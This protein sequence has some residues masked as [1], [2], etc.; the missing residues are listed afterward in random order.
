MRK[1]ILFVSILM[2]LIASISAIYVEVGSGTATTNY[3]PA[4]GFYSYGWSR[5]I[6]LQSELIN[7]MEITAISYDVNNAPNNFNLNN[8]SYYMRHTTDS[9]IASTDY[10]DPATDTSFELVFSGSITYDGSG[11]HQLLLDTA[12]D[13]NGTD[14]LEI[15]VINNMGSWNSPYP[16]F[17]GTNET[18]ERAVYQYAD[19]TFPTGTG[20]YSG[21]FPNARFYFTAEGEP[22][23]ATLTTPSNNSFNVQAPMELAWTNGAD[24]D[25]VK[26]YLSD[27]I[28]QVSGMNPAALLADNYIQESYTVAELTSLTNYYWRI[29]SANEAT[30]FLVP[31]A[32]WKFTTAAADGSIV[33]GN[34]TEIN[35]SL[36]MEPYWGYTISQSIYE[37]E[38][39]DVDDQVIQQVSYYYNGN[40]S[41]TED[42]KVYL[43]HTTLSSFTTTGSWVPADELLLVY[44]GPMSV[45]SEEGWVTINLSAPFVY[46][47]TDNLLVAFSCHTPGYHS[48][49]DE[50]FGTTT[51]EQNSIVYYSDSINSNFV[52]PSPGTLKSIIP[53]ILLT[54]VDI[55]TGASIVVPQTSLDYGDIYLNRTGVVELTISNWGVEDLE[56]DF[57]SAGTELTFTPADLTITSSSTA[58]VTVELDPLVEG[59]YSG[60]FIINSNDPEHPAI[61]IHTT[62]FILP[63]LPEGVAMIG[64]G[65]LT[66]QGLP[67]EPFYRHSYSQSIYYGNE[68]GI[69]NQQLETIS[70]HYNGN[71]AWGPDEFKIYMGLTT[72]TQFSGNTGWI[73]ADDMMEVFDGTI[74]VPSTAGLVEIVLDTP[75]NYNSSQNLVVGVFYSNASYHSSSDE[76]YCTP[77]DVT[78]SILYYGDGTPPTH[79]APPTANYMRNCYPN[80]RL[81]FGEVPEG[82]AIRINPVAIDFGN[83]YLNR[84][85]TARFNIRNIGTETLTGNLPVAETEL[86]FSLGDFVIEPFEFEQVVVTLTPIAEGAYNGSFIID[87]NDPVHLVTTVTTT[88]NIL[89]ALPEGLVIIGDGTLVDQGLPIEPWWRHSYSQSIYYADEIGL[90]DQRVE[91]IS[92]H[93]NGDSAWGPDAIKIYMG[94]TDETS[95]SSTS[96]W[97]SIDDMMEVYDGGITVSAV[98]E[99]IEIILDI[100]FNYSDSQNLVVA[101]FKTNPDYHSSNS[102][103]YCT[104]TATARSLYYYS[105]ST[106]PDPSAPPTASYLR[107]CYPNVRLQFGEV[108]DAP[109]LTVYPHHTTY[110]MVPVDGFSMEKT[111]TMRSIGLQD[112][113]IPSAPTL[114]GTNPDQ[115]SI[116]TDNNTYPLVLPLGELAT[117][118]VTFSPTSEGTK[119]ATLIV[120]GGGDRRETYTA[121]LN[122]Y[123]YADD[124]NDQPTGAT[125]L[126][127]PV[128]GDTYAIM[129]IGDVDWYKIPAM[130]IGDTLMAHTTM[131]GGSNVNTKLWLYGPVTDPANV[132]G[133]AFIASGFDIDHV[134]PAS[135]DFYLRVAE[136]YVNPSRSNPHTRKNFNGE[137]GRSLRD[138]TGLYNLFVSAY[139]NYAYNAPLNLEATNQPGFVELTW[140]EPE[141]E[142]YLIGYNVYRNGSVITP[143][144]IPI[145]TNIYHDAEVVVGVEYTYYVVGMYEEP[146][147]FSLPSNSIT[148]TYFNSGEP[149][150]GDDFEEHPDFALTLPNWIQYDVDGGDTY[151]IS[152]IEF[153]NQ[154]EPMSY[155]VFN[156][157]STTP[158][159]TDMIP[160]SGDK[161]VA[162]FA[163]SEGENNDWII[164][165]RIIIGTTT[166]VSF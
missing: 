29:V 151:G 69:T 99:P 60:S 25:W 19:G 144:M 58:I 16:V 88:A 4:Y 39:I 52:S 44:D 121:N 85:G 162:S 68:I 21:V 152:N 153:E 27:D 138:D 10:V 116:T 80:V 46:N 140:V 104:P 48:S 137:T 56:V 120:T 20:Y 55:P 90:S 102:E 6:Y 145:G 65:N 37:Q 136:N 103:F 94:L 147:G 87:S 86:N 72:E 47:N 64:T 15:A 139:Y 106:V 75:F 67:F 36:P 135:G 93:Y 7:E 32:V 92:W 57:T 130:G 154:G 2:L 124:G 40:S 146:D 42:V 79:E 45:P 100:P 158:P 70:W 89:P 61:T 160:Q 165:P 74:S 83:V 114:G 71:S 30:D 134:L 41:W 82:P 23:M 163:S 22:S 31:S 5:T 33:I 9:S 101:V 28:Q 81:Q 112:I 11:W 108:P 133:T 84:T 129:P 35:T 126:T 18:P 119:S 26:V 77:T 62:A 97:L 156:P 78:R 142:R 118:G 8:Q 12:F 117:V 141:Y 125:V 24:T 157:A 123:A 113:T 109:D 122:G 66:N 53:N 143:A 107:N 54:M 51:T 3:I 105:D 49:S 115:F 96:S 98:A 110:E 59:V 161:F 166:V 1:K 95:F 76:F 149:L 91:K 43:A 148:L 34:G 73:S 38:W 131:A 128:E 13:Y 50:F 14:N 127:L 150:W 132:S 63:A 164:T 155:I 111:F 17:K 159:I